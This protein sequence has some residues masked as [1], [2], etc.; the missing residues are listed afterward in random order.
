MERILDNDPYGKHTK[1][2]FKSASKEDEVYLRF[3][4][5]IMFN[6]WSPLDENTRET[7]QAEVRGMRKMS[8]FAKVD[9][10]RKFLTNNF[11]SII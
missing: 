2:K 8:N 5:V 7:I 11:G 6:M 9:D 4:E 3:S 10:V 1:A